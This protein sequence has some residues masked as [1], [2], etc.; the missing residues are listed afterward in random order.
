MNSKAFWKTLMISVLGTWVLTLVAGYYLFPENHLSAW[1]FFI[2]LLVIHAS[3]LVI[4]FKIG[5]EKGLSTQTIV[6]KTLIY[7]FTWWVPVKKGIIEE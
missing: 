4:S 5:K 6:I 1:R 3:E 7:G 2:A